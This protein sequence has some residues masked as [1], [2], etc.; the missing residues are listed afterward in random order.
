MKDRLV[1]EGPV[2][3]LQTLEDIAEMARVYDPEFVNLMS[4]T[5][6]HQVQL[7]VVFAEVNRTGM[8]ELGIN[9]MWGDQ[10]LGFGLQGPQPTGIALANQSSLSGIFNGD[11]YIPAPSSG[12]FQVLGRLG[13]DVNLT[14]I[15]AVLEQNSLSKTLARPTLVAMSGQ[16]AEFLAGGE[17]PI[18]VS[19]SGSRITIEFK[20]YGVKLVFVPTVLDGEVV[21]LR[22]YTEVSDIDSAT[23]IRLTGVEIPG[24]LSRKTQS[25]LRIESGM[26]FAMAGMMHESM[27]ATYAKVPVLG[28]I[29]VIGIPFRYVQHRRNESELIVLVTPRLVRPLAAGELPPLPGETE[30]SN[31][32]DVELFL[33]GMDHRIGSRTATPTGPVGLSR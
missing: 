6:D 2:P 19:Q 16:Q 10:N 8:R 14:A 21:D 28:S 4:V 25:H 22:V 26:T 32:T 1:V 29:P 30:N 9:G 3:D 18:P 15:L 33:L 12:T 23:S 24:F 13:K 27:R 31:P 11:G 5:G 17:V 20:E 7:E